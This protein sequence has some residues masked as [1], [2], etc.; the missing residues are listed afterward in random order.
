MNVH[1]PPWYF[2]IPHIPI[3]KSICSFLPCWF[4]I[5]F[6]V[7]DW[8]PARWPLSA[9]FIRARPVGGSVCVLMDRLSGRFYIIYV[10]SIHYAKHILFWGSQISKNN[11]RNSHCQR[12]SGFPSTLEKHECGSCNSAE[13]DSCA[14]GKRLKPDTWKICLS[15]QYI[16]FNVAKQEARM[17][18]CKVTLENWLMV[19][20]VRKSFVRIHSYFMT[21]S[22]ERCSL[23]LVN[24]KGSTEPR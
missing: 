21:I 10:I 14:H 13:R 19:L 15:W 7:N 3:Q 16:Y 5:S 9:E 20:E 2:V 18:F 17:T 8:L 6:A 4:S 22:G 11:C 23:P 12:S 1:E 24:Q